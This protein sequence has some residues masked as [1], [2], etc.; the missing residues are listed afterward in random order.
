MDD[1]RT[2]NLT[3]KFL[4]PSNWTSENYEK[5]TDKVYAGFLATKTLPLYDWYLLADDDTFIHMKNLKLFLQSKKS[6]E[7]VQYGFHY[8]PKGGFLSGG[9]GF[10]FSKEAYKRLIKSLSSSSCQNTGIDDLDLSTCLKLSN[11]KIGDSR[12]QFGYERFHPDSFEKHFYGPTDTGKFPYYEQFSGKKCCSKDW[13]SFHEKNHN[14]FDFMIDF[15]DDA[16]N[17]S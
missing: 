10:V 6:T 3:Y 5:L 17:S 11:V 16:L 1:A 13:I 15:V 9:A 14:L 4:H 12:D 7:A 8:R 2:K